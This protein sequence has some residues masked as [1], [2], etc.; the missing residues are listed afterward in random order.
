[1]SISRIGKPEDISNLVSFLVSE[2]ANYITGQTVSALLTNKFKHHLTFWS[3]HKLVGQ[4]RRRMALR[5][6][7]AYVAAHFQSQLRYTNSGE[8]RMMN[9]CIMF[10][11]PIHLR[12]VPVA[13]SR[14]RRLSQ[15]GFRNAS[16]GF[17]HRTHSESVSLC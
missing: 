3:H 1:M 10:L 14:L 16:H 13:S 2:D 17:Q 5:L 12:R 8:W 9:E 6:I 7:W 15:T 4:R 11:V